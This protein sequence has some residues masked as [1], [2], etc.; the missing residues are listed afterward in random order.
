[1]VIF[2]NEVERKRKI[3]DD[4]IEAA[5]KEREDEYSKY[6]ESP[7]TSCLFIYHELGRVLNKVMMACRGG[8][9]AHQSESDSVLDENRQSPRGVLKN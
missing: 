7:T 1:M 3:R 8:S 4:G 9:Q 6:A 5:K 2:D